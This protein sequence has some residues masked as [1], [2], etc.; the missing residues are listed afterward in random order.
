MLKR[1]YLWI[2]D[3]CTTGGVGGLFASGGI[4]EAFNDSLEV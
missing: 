2:V 3:E 1:S 4:L